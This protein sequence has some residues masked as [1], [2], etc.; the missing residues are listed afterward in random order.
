MLPAADPSTSA[1]LPAAAAVGGGAVDV[2]RA[3]WADSCCAT[4][5]CCPCSAGSS[6]ACHCAICRA[7]HCCW[8][9]TA[10]VCFAKLL[11]LLLGPLLLLLSPLGLALSQLLLLLQGRVELLPQLQHLLVSHDQFSLIPFQKLLLSF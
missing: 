3:P 2:R 1:C 6:S 11:L 5:C 8:S 10:A 9:A 7:S 4:P